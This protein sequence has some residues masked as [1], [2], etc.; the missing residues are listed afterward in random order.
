M[1]A[2]SSSTILSVLLI[3]FVVLGPHCCRCEQDNA[4][5]GGIIRR[6]E[7][8]RGIA[9]S[10][11]YGYSQMVEV[12]G[13]KRLVMLSGQ[14]GTDASGKLVAGG[15]D[16][17]ANQAWDNIEAL[18]GEAGCSFP[19]DIVTHTAYLTDRDDFGKY[20]EIRKQRVG[21]SRPSSTLVVVTALAPLESVEGSEGDEGLVE[22]TVTAACPPHGQ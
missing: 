11:Q 20:V 6:Y 10:T 12:Q 5:K 17:Q 1:S 19:D 13:N 14:M 9:D 16:G 18:F 22:V 15:F 2:S 7:A 8:P 4:P 3:V 21:E